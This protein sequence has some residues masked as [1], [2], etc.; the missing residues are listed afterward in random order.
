M[1]LCQTDMFPGTI[2]L[3]YIDPSRHFIGVVLPETAL[4][5]LKEEERRVFASHQGNGDLTV[6]HMILVLGCFDLKEEERTLFD[7][8][9]QHPHQNFPW[10]V[11]GEKRQA[12]AEHF[13]EE[14]ALFRVQ[15]LQLSSGETH[16]R[17][18][19]R[20]SFSFSPKH[21]E[22]LGLILFVQRY[23]SGKSDDE[24]LVGR[25]EFGRQGEL[26]LETLKVLFP[27]DNTW[28]ASL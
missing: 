27:R 12:V 8:I 19:R 28:R 6:H 14:L 17:T 18:L 11:I 26:V 25:W 5:F 15:H 23:L 16:A 3:Q 2:V 13:T 21:A 20:R 1:D 24:L 4:R 7:H 10:Y 9:G 22:T